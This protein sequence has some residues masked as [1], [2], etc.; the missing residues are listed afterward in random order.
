MTFAVLTAIWLETGYVEA[1]GENTSLAV[2]IL[3][4]SPLGCS[5]GSRATG[6]T[7]AGS[8]REY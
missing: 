6:M 8:V 3:S 7:S 4:E 5:F 2:I 1:K